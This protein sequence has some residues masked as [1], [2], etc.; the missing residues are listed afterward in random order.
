MNKNPK[1]DSKLANKNISQIFNP[2]KEELSK[3]KKIEKEISKMLNN[4]K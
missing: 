4:F 3:H 1:V 2:K